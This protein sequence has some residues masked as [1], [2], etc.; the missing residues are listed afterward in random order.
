MMQRLSSTEEGL[1]ITAVNKF[2]FG[3][4]RYGEAR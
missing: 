3:W 1:G 4:V 2:R